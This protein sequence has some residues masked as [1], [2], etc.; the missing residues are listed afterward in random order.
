MKIIALYATKD[1]GKTS[2]LNKLIDLLSLIA[3]SYELNRDYETKAYFEINNK[4]IV[5]CTAGD[6]DEEIK[7]NIA[8]LQK[9]NHKKDLFVTAS[10]TRG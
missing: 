6:D 3:D 5:V 4:G 1:R 9:S 10:H 8:F 2:T 7:A